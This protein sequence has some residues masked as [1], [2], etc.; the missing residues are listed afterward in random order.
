MFRKFFGLGGAAAMLLALVLIAAG[1]GS[2][3]SSSSGGTIALLL[4]ENHTP[5]YEARDKPEFETKV[6][7][8]CSDC[9]ILYSNAEQDASKQ[10][11]QAEAALTQ[12]AKVLV[13]RRGRRRLRGLDRQEGQGAERARRQL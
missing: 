13:A 9:K 3:N 10:Q 7:E 5:R 12:G 6:K 8:L 2:D 1:C 4:P 11:N